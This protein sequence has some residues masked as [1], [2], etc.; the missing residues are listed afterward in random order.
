MNTLVD[1]YRVVLA[2]PITQLSQ[3]MGSN[4]IIGPGLSMGV[5]NDGLAYSKYRP[6]PLLVKYVEVGWLGQR[7]KLGFY[8][9][10]GEDTI[11]VPT[12]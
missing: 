2:A 9:F 1:G 12:R 4:L 6:C 7:T 5:L 11:P 10:R 8:D 3:L